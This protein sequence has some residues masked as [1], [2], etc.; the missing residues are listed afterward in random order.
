[1]IARRNLLLVATAVFSSACM[2]MGGAAGAPQSND[3]YNSDAKFEA[4]AARVG[5]N[6]LLITIKDRA[7]QPVTGATVNVG[8]DMTTMSHPARG[9]AI[10]KGGGDYTVRVPM[11]MAGTWRISIEVSKPGS[12]DGKKQIDVV[13]QRN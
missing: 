2:N 12:P 6:D 9:K 5:Q 3:A 8:V 10:E 7:G 4:G 1:M 11:S 13:A